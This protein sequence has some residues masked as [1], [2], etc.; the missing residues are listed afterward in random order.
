MSADHM[1]I[2]ETLTKVYPGGTQALSGI[3]FTVEAGEV[4][5]FLGPNGAG[6]STTLKILS[7]LIRKTSGRVVVAGHDV[8]RDPRAIR[9]SIGFAMQE[10]GLDDISTGADFL[11]LQ[12]LLYGL[13]RR[14]ARRRADDLLD[15]LGLRPV[16]RRKVGTYSG[17]MR[18][19]V[20]LAAALVHEPP[21]L[22]LDEPTTGLD[23][24]SRL[25]VWDHLAQL[26]ESGVTIFLTTQ[27]MD[28]A[29]RLCHRLAIIG[30]GQI[31]TEGTP[32]ALKDGLG[33]DLIHLTV[34][35]EAEDGSAPDR[36]KK[37]LMGRGLV[38]STNEVRHELTVS[39]K[40]AGSAVPEILALL[41]T[42]KPVFPILGV[43]RLNGQPKRDGS[44]IVRFCKAS[45]SP[46]YPIRDT[47]LAANHGS[48][49][50]LSSSGPRQW[51]ESALKTSRL[52]GALSLLAR[53]WLY[54]PSAWRRR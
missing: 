7:T 50:S 24:Q 6:K 30:N 15:L 46:V 42:N 19:R 40:G 41:H 16:A 25:A 28:E 51:G 39:V 13:S 29:D 45:Q 11:T 1:V 44:T 47:I 20:D 4:F 21:V 3:D 37:L 2:V 26:Q 38:P 27:M 36:A 17:G 52:P 53:S 31:V 14:D 32:E 8:D 43:F 18:R 35:P 23:P 9:R 5:G 33:G 10:V 22:F 48:C 12:G 54:P 49:P 34:D